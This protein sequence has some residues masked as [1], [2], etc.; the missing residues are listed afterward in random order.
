MQPKRTKSTNHENTPYFYRPFI[1]I[2]M[3]SWRQDCSHRYVRTFN[4]SG[5]LSKYIVLFEGCPSS[6]TS[7]CVAFSVFLS[8]FF[9][10]WKIMCREAKMLHTQKY[11]AQFYQTVGVEC[12]HEE[13]PIWRRFSPFHINFVT[14]DVK[15][16]CNLRFMVCWMQCNTLTF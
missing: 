12:G 4:I 10:Q 11:K 15:I 2:Y 14:T 5:V 6:N 1:R 8:Q 13:A 9:S 16:T 3:D 7:Y